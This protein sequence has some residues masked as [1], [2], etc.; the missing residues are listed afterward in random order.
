MWWLI[1]AC[2]KSQ[3]PAAAA[4]AP[5]DAVTSDPAPSE[6]H[7][8]RDPAFMAWVKVVQHTLSV[9]VVRPPR[10]EGAAPR[11]CDVRLVVDPETGVVQHS[12]LVSSSGDPVFDRAALEGIAGISELPPQPP[13]YRPLVAQGITFR[14]VD[15]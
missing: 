11:S 7:P 2:T 9:A 3:P 8:A 14:V 13:R 12:E 5:P 10:P 6:T 15:P 4:A 1:L